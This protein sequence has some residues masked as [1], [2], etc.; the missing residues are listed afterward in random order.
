MFM[1]KLDIGNNAKFTKSAVYSLHYNPI[2]QSAFYPRSAVC[3]L[4]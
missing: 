2:L 1:V 4:H 3:V